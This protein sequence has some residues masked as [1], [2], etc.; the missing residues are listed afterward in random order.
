M[1]NDNNSNS[2]PIEALVLT[3]ENDNEIEFDL[4]DRFDFEGSSYCVLLPVDDDSDD[5]E[6]VILRDEGDGAL[7]GIETEE[8]LDR[9]FNEYKRRNSLEDN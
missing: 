4:M 9:V 7:V 1:Q 3:D 2:R 6:Y 8:L 5:I